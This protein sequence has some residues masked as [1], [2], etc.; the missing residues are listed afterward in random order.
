MT[1]PTPVPASKLPPPIEAF[2]T[3]CGIIN[4]ENVQRIFQAFSTAINKQ[5]KH[6]H[7][8]FHSTG[9][10]INDG[11][12]LYNFFK[13]VPLNFT[14][15]NVG[16]IQSAATTAYLG[17][18]NRKTS[19][20]ATFMIHR[21]VGCFQP[22]PSSILQGI[23]ESVALDDKRTEAILRA[24]KIGLT[25]AQWATITNCDLVLSSEEAIKAGIA[26]LGDF[27]PP[28]GAEFFSL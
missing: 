4:Q 18:K 12:A 27:V 5:Y 6:I 2:G 17:A 23:A 25:P 1:E 19:A 15:Y 8:L 11:I 28:P 9:G 24:E 10:M 3:F 21:T 26:T 14:L 22:A 13:T 7:L 20:Y 16:S